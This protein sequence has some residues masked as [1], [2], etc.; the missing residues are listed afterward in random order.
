MKPAQ[1]T[2]V[3]LVLDAGARIGEG[4][5]WDV[6][7]RRLL[8][9]D[10]LARQVHRYDPETGQNETWTFEQQVGAV[11]ARAQ[12]GFLLALEDGFWTTEGIGAKPRRLAGVEGD[13]QSARMNDGKC[14]RRGRFWAGTMAH[15]ARPEAG[16]LYRL[17]PGGAVTRILERVTISNGIG[18]SP[19]SRTMYYVDSL[20][21]AV[22]AF[23]YD[24]ATGDAVNRRQ[25]I[26]TPVGEGLPDGLAVDSEGFL[27]IAFYGGWSVHRYTPGGKLERTVRLPVANV[28]SCAFGGPDL[29]DLYI[30]SGASGLSNQERAAQPLAGGLFRHRPGVLGLPESPF[31]G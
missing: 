7:T 31:A 10:I 8:W 30:T 16:S 26:R 2:S 5:S 14:D 6:A 29:G 28:T 9:V 13:D 21:Y 12:G 4:P 27:W 1:A 25:I 23:D 15:D 18:W 20:T 11:V 22:D 19:D 24:L 3:E 17:D